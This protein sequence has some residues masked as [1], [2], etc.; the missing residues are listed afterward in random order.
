MS[1]GEEE[2]EEV[3]R[4]IFLL[5]WMRFCLINVYWQNGCVEKVAQVIS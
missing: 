2:V 3:E 5:R 1:A 4:T